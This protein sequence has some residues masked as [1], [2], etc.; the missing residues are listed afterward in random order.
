MKIGAA[1]AMV[2]VVRRAWVLRAAGLA[3]ILLS[4]GGT[5]ADVFNLGGTFNTVTG[6]WNGLASVQFVT[7]GN[8]GNGADLQRL[9]EIRTHPGSVPYTFRMDAFDVTAGQYCAFLNAVAVSHDPYNLYVSNM[10]ST[11]GIQ[12]FGSG[13]YSVAS[14]WANRPV[15]N[16]RWCEAARFCNWLTNGQ[17][18]GAE[19]PGTTETGSYTLN[20][21]TSQAALMAVTRNADAKY[22]IPTEDE[23]YKA[24]YYDPTLNNGA[25]GYWTYP[26]RS[27]TAPTAEAPP[28]GTNSANIA[29]SSGS[30]VVPG[31]YYTSEVGAYYASHSYYG[32][33]E[34]GGN[35]MQWNEANVSGTSRGVRGGNWGLTALG[36]ADYIYWYWPPVDGFSSTGFRV[37]E[38]PEPASVAALLLGGAGLMRKRRGKLRSSGASDLEPIPV[39]RRAAKGRS[40]PQAKARGRLRIS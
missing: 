15:T 1:F 10:A 17:P 14:N 28:G 36:T 19:G 27:N 18:T 21:A 22:V 12:W 13:S 33:F 40:S 2:V 4:A 16:V 30:Y 20:G 26:T 34:M 25:G 31:G 35:V 39:D 5:R 32:A 23:W 7:V 37:A 11:C 8:P 3:A 9:G 24:A 38:V 29:Y 6:S